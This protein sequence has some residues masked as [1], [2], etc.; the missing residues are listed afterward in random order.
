MLEDFFQDR[1]ALYAAG[2]MTEDERESFESLL[3]V[4]PELCH[5][6]AGFLETAAT[7]TLAANPPAGVGPSPTMKHCVTGLIANRAQHSSMTESLVRSDADG[8]VQWVNPAFTEMC[9]YT[10][11]ELHGKKLGPILQGEKTDRATAERMRQAVHAHQP[12]RETILNYHKDGRPYWVHIAIT[13]VFD[14]SGRPIL[15]IARENA[16]PDRVAV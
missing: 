12:C 6:V 15:M 2:A 7:V 13:P 16:L 11:D 5:L 9:G 14:E 3:E 10:L 4:Y 8:F 1:A